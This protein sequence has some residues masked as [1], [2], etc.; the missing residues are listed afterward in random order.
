MCI[1]SAVDLSQCSNFTYAVFCCRIQSDDG[2]I[3]LKKKFVI[4]QRT[5]Y[6]RS[7]FCPLMSFRQGACVGEWYILCHL[8]VPVI[9]SWH[10]CSLLKSQHVKWPQH[11]VQLRLQ[12]AVRS[13]TCTSIYTY[14]PQAQVISWVSQGAIVYKRTKTLALQCRA[15]RTRQCISSTSSVTRSRASTSCKVTQDRCSTSASTTTRACSPRATRT[16]LS[17]CGSERKSRDS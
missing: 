7:S 9:V 15:V 13:S 6:V 17:S 4:K 3:V 12:Q 11:R 14:L 16:A 1:V 5:Q 8:K 2:A 10:V